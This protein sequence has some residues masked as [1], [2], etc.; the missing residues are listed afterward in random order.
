[1]E[2]QEL[3]HCWWESKMLQP[4][5][6]TVGHILT[7][8]P[9]NPIPDY[10]YMK[11][12]ISTFTEALFKLP[13]PGNNPNVL[14]RVNGYINCGIAIRQNATH[15]QKKRTTDTCSNLDKSQ[16]FILNERSQSQKATYHMIPLI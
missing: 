12:C 9:S 5:H 6:R 2:Q 1:M 14:P 11:P 10:V 8:S 15:H 4:V 3:A 13:K 16:K 7:T